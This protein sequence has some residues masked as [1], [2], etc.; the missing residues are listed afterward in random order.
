MIDV[1]NFNSKKA[2]VLIIG[3]FGLFLLAWFISLTFGVLFSETSETV[4]IED[5]IDI[6]ENNTHVEIS[7]KDESYTEYFVPYVNNQEIPWDNNQI[8]IN[9]SES[10]DIQ[11]QSVYTINDEEQIYETKTINPILQEYSININEEDNNYITNIDYTVSVDYETE[12]PMNINWFIND[13]RIN[14]QQETFEYLFDDSGEY[15]ISLTAEISDREIE[16]NE[17]FYIS[18]PDE[19]NIEASVRNT[20]IDNSTPQTDEIV[21]EQYD[22]LEFTVEE[23]SDSNVD[24]YRW[25]FD[26]GAMGNGETQL[27]WYIQPNEYNVSVIAENQETGVTDTDNVNVIVEEPEEEPEMNRLTINTFDGVTGERVENV[28]IVIDNIVSDTTTQEGQLQY[29][30]PINEY[31]IIATHEDYETYEES[32]ALTDNTVIDMRL[33]PETE[34]EDD[35]DDEIEEDEQTFLGQSTNISADF[36]TEVINETEEDQPTQYDEILNNMDGNGT[37]DNPYI[38]TTVVEL[39]AMNGDPGAYYELGNDI[40]AEDTQ[41]WGD[42][43]EFTEQFIGTV[44]E[45]QFE[46]VYAPISEGSVTI[47]VEDSTIDEEEYIINEETGSII[48]TNSDEYNQNSNVYISYQ[49]DNV[50]S[51]FE[52]I[53]SQGKSPV[54]DGKGY[55]INNLN[56]QHPTQNNVGLFDS[57]DGSIITNVTFNGARITGSN[58]VGTIA[59]E[60]ERSLIEDINVGS[61]I[62]GERN[63]GSIVGSTQTTS[64]SNVSSF[65]G[66]IG[67]ELTGGL[68]GQ[69]TD[70]TVI[71]QSRIESPITSTT[72]L[73]ETNS[74]GFIGMMSESDIQN[75]YSLSNIQLSTN[76]DKIGGFVGNQLENSTINN[77][78][79]VTQ[80]DEQ[81]SE[82]I[83]SIAGELRGEITNMYW[84][85]DIMDSEIEIINQESDE[86]NIS[87]TNLETQEM[88]GEIAETN[89]ESFDFTNIWDTVTEPEDNYPVFQQKQDGIFTPDNLII[90]ETNISSD[91]DVISVGDIISTSPT[92]WNELNDML[93]ITIYESNYEVTNETIDGESSTTVTQQPII[94]NSQLELTNFEVH[95]ENEIDVLYTVLDDNNES[96]NS[97]DNELE[98]QALGEDGFVEDANIMIEHQSLDYSKEQGEGDFFK[99]DIPSGF[100]NVSITSDTY[101]NEYD[102]IEITD[103]KN[104]VYNLEKE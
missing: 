17:Q 28:D 30:L 58:H 82:N 20:E 11:I 68:V 43:I 6:F 67:T 77:S 12:Q 44:S 61:Q 92:Y 53:Q 66:I 39:Q 65:S 27:K 103:D 18:E 21:V 54:F 81:Y 47:Q 16:Y 52:P 102:G 29:D 95:E 57:V 50:Y 97:L 60:T 72:I 85:S 51:G 15:D 2:I 78:Y 71:E 46:T 76:S 88:Q 22:E 70:N 101:E 10:E 45:E 24:T 59:G 96:I 48:L 64:I 79:T 83:G 3:V 69:I 75:S 8:S 1:D 5:N 4:E 41:L 91:T 99:N 90:T 32:I 19:I 87:I 63:T 33:I 86:E 34:E 23:L 40:N 26:D 56:I 35:V 94:N 80:I 84:D 38:I 55:E 100:Y 74:G 62:I 36:E 42:E 31:N 73:E 93:D 25:D 104:V 13:E 37:V 89:M 9:K 7:V 98:I 14:E 49:L